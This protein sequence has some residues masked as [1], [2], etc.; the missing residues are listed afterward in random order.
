[1]ETF[2]AVALAQ[3]VTLAVLVSA[4]HHKPAKVVVKRVLMVRRNRRLRDG[5]AIVVLEDRE[6]QTLSFGAWVITFLKCK[7]GETGV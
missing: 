5:I 2:Q 3:S 7:N 4:L 6:G 1:M